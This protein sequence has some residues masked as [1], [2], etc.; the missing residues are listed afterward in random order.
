MKKHSYIVLVIVLAMML[1]LVGCGPK[2]E[3][4]PKEEGQAQT[5]EKKDEAKEEEKQDE[6]KEEGKE[7]GKE[8]EKKEESKE[9]ETRTIVDMDG[10]E[11][12]VPK[13][14]KRVVV[15]S[16]YPLPSV[17]TTYL[18]SGKKVV[19]MDPFAYAAA[20]NGLLGK[21]FPDILEAN[22]SFV[23][24]D[25][26]NVEELI[27]LNPDVVLY[28]AVDDKQKQM[29]ESAGLTGIAVHA[30]QNDY[31]VIQTYNDWFRLMARMFPGEGPAEDAITNYSQKVYDSIQERIKDI[32]EEERVRA[33]HIFR[34]N[35]KALIVSGRNFFGNFWITMAGGINVAGELQDMGPSKVNMEQIYAWDPEL[36]YITN[37]SQAMPEDLANNAIGS[38]DWSSI[39]AVQEGRVHKM[40]LGSY[41][42]FTPG[43]D[44]PVTLLWVAKQ[45]Y[46]EK[47]ADIDIAKEFKD[48]YKNFFNVE[49]TDEDIEGILNP[50]R[51]AAGTW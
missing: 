39:K 37:F 21:L 27:K 20:E 42:T 48:Y 17:I 29:L 25:A 28:R 2:E 4:K 8:E 26:V 12:V 33:L 41:R 19:G 18:G 14:I 51:E 1:S 3:Q 13:E 11:V 35:D 36:I 22:T 40:P 23:E 34:Y 16:M 31:N 47:F 9:G 49:L 45:M 44:T 5:E 43:V 32:P 7:E 6:K 46:P 24:G 15:L 50:P 30:Q 38:D 10:N